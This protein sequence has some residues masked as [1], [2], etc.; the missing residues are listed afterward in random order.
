MQC[1]FTDSK[2]VE[3]RDDYHVGNGGM[4]FGEVIP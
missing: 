4:V 1:V 2:E 3:E